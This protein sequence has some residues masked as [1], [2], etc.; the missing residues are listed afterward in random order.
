MNEHICMNIT[1][2]MLISREREKARELKLLIAKRHVLARTKCK[3]FTHVKSSHYSSSHTL[4]EEKYVFLLSKFA[5]HNKSICPMV[6]SHTHT[7][8]Y[9]RTV[10]F[11]SF[12]YRCWWWW[13]W[14]LLQ[15]DSHFNNNNNAVPGRSRARVHFKEVNFFGRYKRM[16]VCTYMYV[17]VSVRGETSRLTW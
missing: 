4:E 16:Y 7:H 11:F 15:Q 14:W 12:S 13:W 17:W 3:V 2:W 9:T 10:S 1:V 6:I 8:S 5:L